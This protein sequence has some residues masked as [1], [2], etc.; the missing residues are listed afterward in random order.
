MATNREN[1]ATLAAANEESQKKVMSPKEYLS[2][3]LGMSSINII[4][5]MTSQLTYFY[6]NMVGMAPGLAGTVLMIPRIFDAISDIIM[7]NVFDR[8]DN[9]EGKVKPWF[10]RMLLLLPLSII[11]LFL[12]PKASPMIQ[13]G[14]AVLTNVFACAVCFTIIYIPYLALMNYRTKNSEE[15]GKMG[16][17]RQIASY[18]VGYGITITLIPV[19]T[20]L[21]GN[22]KAWIIYALFF[23]ILSFVCLLICYKG[24]QERYRETGE[25]AEEEK[26]L[27]T[28]RSLGILMRNSYWVKLTVICL[29]ITIV[30]A[31]VNSA[32]VYYFQYVFGNANLWSVY[33]IIGLAASIAG[34][35]VTPAMI[36]RLGMVNTA[37]YSYLIA[38]A[39]CLLRG[40]LR[41]NLIAVYASNAIL[42]IGLAAATAVVPVLVMNSAE[43]NKY[44]FDVAL[45]GMTASA[46][47]FSIKV[48]TGVGTAI[49]GFVLQVGRFDAAL[50][51]QPAS[52]INA[53]Y[54]LNIWIPFVLFIISF[55][56]I[57]TVD[58][59]K[60][61]SFYV[62]EN[63]KKEAAK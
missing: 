58:L 2:D 20:A 3:S 28:L 48:A 18:A 51:E 43:Y 31:M 4:S 45:C 7:G 39:G 34:F 61:Y 47:S 35:V 16:V 29:L 23:T 19:T 49:I 42:M 36:K 1:A 11:L 54:S 13:G 46:N 33:N 56:I 57:M 59:D 5:I 14:Y 32:P 24:I 30:Y 26:K 10:R 12:V 37:K 55:F 22:R 44:K 27:S 9:P 25:G 60:K 21:G 53:I 52:A 41:T 15:R 17:Y 8:S 6:T 50:A 38:S 63:E 40:L 62:A